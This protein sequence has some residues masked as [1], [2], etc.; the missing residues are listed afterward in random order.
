M[1]HYKTILCSD[2]KH[3]VGGFWNQMILCAHCLS[4]T[5][6]TNAEL[7]L[8]KSLKINAFLKNMS[9][10]LAHWCQP[11]TLHQKNK[12]FEDSYNN[13][14]ISNRR[15]NFYSVNNKDLE[16]MYGSTR[17]RAIQ[18]TYK[19]RRRYRYEPLPFKSKY[20]FNFS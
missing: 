10:S 19:T 1:F 18:L 7:A 20:Q 15:T 17:I 9:W 8:S 2:R 13:A 12:Q 5:A 11:T 14:I 3:L 6:N 16:V 4:L